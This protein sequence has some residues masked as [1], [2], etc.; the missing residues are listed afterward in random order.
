MKPHVLT[1]EQEQEIA[2]RLELR[3]A[4]SDKNLM[5]EFG[6]SRSVLYR[7]ANEGP[8]QN[9]PR[10][11]VASSLSPTQRSWRS[12]MTRCYNQNYDAY[13]RYGGR[14]IRVCE[15]WQ[16]FENFLADMS[17]RPAGKTLD[18]YPNN[19][20]NYEPGNCRWA[21]ASEQSTNRRSRAAQTKQKVSIESML[22]TS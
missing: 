18:R 8:R 11:T 13:P 7:I 12:M 3:R 19:D 1:V 10:G 9:V 14:G 17:E 6:C 5:A 20:G 15:R 22:P 21:T 2:R 4:W 16:K